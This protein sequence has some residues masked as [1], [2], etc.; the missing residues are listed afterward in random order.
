MCNYAKVDHMLK[1]ITLTLGLEQVL[2]FLC[3]IDSVLEP[4]FIS[5]TRGV[6]GLR[7]FAVN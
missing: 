6:S 2:I 4:Q 7:Y 5:A 1:G 3:Q